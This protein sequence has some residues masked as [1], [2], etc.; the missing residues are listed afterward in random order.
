MTVK[1]SEPAP[2]FT[3]PD[4]AGKPVTLS[5]YRGKI[6][7]L[8]FYPKDET[9]VCTK[10][11]CAFRDAYEDF[12]AAGAVVIGAS[13]DSAADHGA[14]SGRLRLPFTLV[15]DEG[16][17][18]RSLYGVPKTLGLLAGRTTYVIDRAGVVRH[19]FTAAF[20]AQKHVDEAL[21]VVRSLAAA[22]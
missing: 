1:P 9:P 18:V 8:Y 13:G 20:S 19:V 17:R 7:V 15:A 4:A 11:A 6:V 2:D 10:E 14:F 12:T 5:G 22:P 3:L 21:A 16:N